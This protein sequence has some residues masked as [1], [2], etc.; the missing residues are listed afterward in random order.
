MYNVDDLILN[1][2]DILNLYSTKSHQFHT[3][4]QSLIMKL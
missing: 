3:I 2:L 4:G 1:I